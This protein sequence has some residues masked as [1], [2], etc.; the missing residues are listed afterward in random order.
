MLLDLP[1]LLLLIWIACLL[2]SCRFPLNSCRSEDKL[3]QAIIQPLPQVEDPYSTFHN[4][5]LSLLYER[6]L[7][8]GAPL[9]TSWTQKSYS[10]TRPR[11][12]LA[13]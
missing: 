4:L 7:S 11:F 3:T 2:R 6:I 12:K 8:I 10:K 1:N 13:N 5:A 9:K